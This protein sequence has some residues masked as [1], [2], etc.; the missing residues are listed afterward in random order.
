MNWLVIRCTYMFGWKF[1]EKS[2]LILSKHKCQRCFFLY[3]YQLFIFY[4]DHRR[5]GLH[6]NIEKRNII[7]M[8]CLCTV[9]RN[10]S[11]LW[12][13]KGKLRWVERLG[14]G[15][16]TLNWNTN[17][18]NDNYYINIIYQDEL[19]TIEVQLLI[20]VAGINMKKIGHSDNQTRKV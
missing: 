8:Y 2:R 13:R 11:L 19:I 7:M 5:R 16:Y 18:Y 15:C 4:T 10:M 6:R 3:F 9:S 14:N 1:I 12:L 17:N 20:R